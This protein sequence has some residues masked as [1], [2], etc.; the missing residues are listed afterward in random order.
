MQTCFAA[1]GA[2]LVIGLMF[3]CM[4]AGLRALD[5]RVRKQTAPEPGSDGP[6]RTIEHAPPHHAQ[7]L[8]YYV[9]SALFWPLAFALG[10]HFLRER[11]T[12]RMGQGC[13]LVGMGALS[14][15]TVLTCVGL[16]GFFYVASS[17]D[18]MA[19][20]RPSDFAAPPRPKAVQGRVGEP[21][22]LND[23]VVVVHA[24]DTT[25]APEQRPPD[26]EG[27][28]WVALDVS[29]RNDGKETELVSSSFLEVFDADAYLARLEL[30]A[31]KHPSLQFVTLPPGQDARGWITFRLPGDAPAKRVQVKRDIAKDVI[32]E[33]TLE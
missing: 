6:Y 13:V 30:Y 32:G 2:I 26:E 28:R 21:V 7:A 3:G 15:L 22:V 18:Q 16:V 8:F 31:P 17:E 23:I 29:F 9:L 5:D 12:A 27:T 14:V 11:S 19:V 20:V 24:V 25:Y 10:V 33:I 4:S 1:I